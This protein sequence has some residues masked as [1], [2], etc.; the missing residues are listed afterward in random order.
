[1]PKIAK[2]FIL[3]IGK[4]MDIG[5]SMSIYKIDTRNNIEKSWANVGSTIKKRLS[6]GLENEQKKMQ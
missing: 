3:G 2:Y 4:T 5:N 6:L 1:M